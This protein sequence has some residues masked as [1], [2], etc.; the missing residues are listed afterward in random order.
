LTIKHKD[1]FSGKIPELNY[2]ASIGE[3][4]DD[5]FERYYQGR[6]FKKQARE[7]KEKKPFKRVYRIREPELRKTELR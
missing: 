4:K 5:S 3:K 7:K 6:R 2:N 1:E